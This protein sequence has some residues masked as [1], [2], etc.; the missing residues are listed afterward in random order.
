M[1]AV[2]DRARRVLSRLR[3][4][5]LLLG[6]RTMLDSYVHVAPSAATAV[7]IFRGEWVSRLPPSVGVVADG[8][9]PLFDDGRVAW[10]ITELGV[11]DADVVELGPLEGGH[12]FMLHQA[13]ARRVVAVEGNTRAFL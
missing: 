1:A 5:K 6:R 12:T 10:A 7:G 11:K 2:V 8:D 3:G 4:R 13:G 9:S